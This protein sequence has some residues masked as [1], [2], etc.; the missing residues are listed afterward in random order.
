[1]HIGTCLEEWHSPLHQPLTSSHHSQVLSQR[2]ASKHVPKN[3]ISIKS[4][5]HSFWKSL[6]HASW[7]KFQD[8][9]FRGLPT[10]TQTF[11][12]SPSSPSYGCCSHCRNALHSQ[13]SQVRNCQGEQQS[14]SLCVMGCPI[15]YQA[16]TKWYK[17]VSF[18]LTQSNVPDNRTVSGLPSIWEGHWGLCQD[19]SAP[20]GCDQCCPLILHS[21][22]TKPHAGRHS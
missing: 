10:Q 19:A 8:K 20:P 18:V 12:L 2:L 21:P 4:F 16:M 1:M 5:G 6:P 13:S 14:A 3:V 7:K 17:Q 15:F 22:A 9:G 11:C